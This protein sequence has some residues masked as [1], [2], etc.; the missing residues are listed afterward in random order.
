M[1]ATDHKTC[2]YIGG[3]AAC[4]FAIIATRIASRFEYTFILQT[5]IRRTHTFGFIQDRKFHF[6]F[7]KFYI[8]HFSKPKF[9]PDTSQMTELTAPRLK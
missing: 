7:P 9:R 4:I 8:P 5:P 1:R 6:F 2:V 3:G